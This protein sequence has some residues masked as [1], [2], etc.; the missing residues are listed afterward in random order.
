MTL[1]STRSDHLVRPRHVVTAVL[2]AHDGAHWLPETLHAVK[3]Q[4]RPVQRFVAI[5]T[6]SRDDT[7]LLLEEGVGEASVLEVP[8]DTGFG[9][10]VAFAVQAFA[11]APGLAST[12]SDAG[13][14]IDWI[15]LLHDDSAPSPGALEALLEL[16][17][18]MPSA[19]VIGPKLQAWDNPRVLLELGLTIDRGGRRETG[20]ESGELDH[21]QHDTVRDVLAVNT[22]GMLVRRDVWD[23]L[24]GLDPALP[25]FRDDLDFGWRANLAGHRVIVCPQ[26][27]VRHAEAASAGTRRTSVVTRYP[28]RV[29]RRAALRTMLVNMSGWWLPVIALRLFLASLVRT[30]AFI[31]T[32]RPADGWDELVATTSVFGHPG[33][34]ARI[35]RSHR[36]MRTERAHQVQRLLAPPGAR[37]QHYADAVGARFA[38]VNDDG[39]GRGLPRRILTQPVLLLVVA[40]TLLTLIAQWKVVGGSLS[41]GA[42]LP[43]PLGA[44]DLWHTY[45]ASWH[46]TGFGS[47]AT[48]PPYLAVLAGLAAILFGSARLVVELVLIGCVPLAGLSAYLAARPLVISVRLRSWLAATYGL[49]PVATGSVAGGRLG[50]AMVV[51]LLPPLLAMLCRSLLPPL[52]PRAPAMRL[53]ARRTGRRLPGTR[54]SWGA[55]LVL[56]AASAFDPVVYLLLGPL[57]VVATVGAVVRRSWW[58]LWRGLVVLVVPPLLLLPW[59]ARLLTHPELFAV[60]IGQQDAGLQASKLPAYDLLLLHPGGPGLPPAWV[61]GGLV[62]VG[63]LGLL[64]LTRPGPARLGWLFACTGLIVGCVISHLHVHIPDAGIGGSATEVAGWPGSATALLGA[65]VLMSVAAAAGRLRPRLSQ[66]SFGWRQ[67]VALIL[68]AAAGLAPVVAGVAWLARGVGPVLTAGPTNVLPAFVTAEF[69]ADGEPRT[70]VL[71]PASPGSGVGGGAGAG[72]A[73]DYAVL[74]NRGPQL[75]DADLPP[76]PAQVSAVSQAVADLAAGAGPLAAT[77]LAHVGIGYVLVPSTRDG[78]LNATIAQAGGLREQASSAAWRLWQV[79]TDA[80]RVA[81]A[82]RGDQAWQLPPGSITVGQAAAPIRVPAVVAATSRFLVLAEAPS[83][84]WQAIARIAGPSAPRATGA[85]TPTTHDGM[86]AF[87]LPA[88]S[89]DVR[90][91]RKPDRRA[92]WLFLELL[93][94]VVAVIAAIPGGPRAPGQQRSR[95]RV[96]PST[97]VGQGRRRYDRTR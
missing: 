76:A 16:A 68:T 13:A 44:S 27:V 91:S 23:A 38:A 50:V 21:G 37:L 92:D 5:D 46:D 79:E 2:V 72:Q 57:I 22:A 47:S 70:I 95:H 8:R 32:K 69:N 66:T 85:L 29:D 55:G 97:D 36:A 12:R 78:G 41:G 1:S 35:R 96:M 67:P 73:V 33:E 45:T 40:L 75:G 48:A 49:L 54:T 11:G 30:V 60:G 82:P 39:S 6:G 4:R 9:V 83:S 58:G 42:L 25:L 61:F 63:L 20:L 71:R 24:D 80:G 64:Q 14:P 7:R 51:I 62:L 18:E 43:A 34:I 94:L 17:D 52:S 3:T 89:I 19:G 28:R 84:S 74:R 53:A 56:A 88:T 86:Q 93:V 59:S 31:I 87:Q 26:A 15:W 10:A 90:I 65:G 77:D 81:I